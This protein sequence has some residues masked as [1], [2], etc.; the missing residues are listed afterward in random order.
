MQRSPSH[1]DVTRGHGEDGGGDGRVRSG[2]D[3]AASLMGPYK[4]GAGQAGYRG[5][6]DVQV[7]VSS[8]TLEGTGRIKWTRHRIEI[9]HAA[10]ILGYDTTRLYNIRIRELVVARSWDRAS[11]LQLC[12]V[13]QFMVRLTVG[14]L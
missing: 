7:A 6:S 9:S 8:G 5:E 2:S 14:R 13:P 11:A 1:S 4:A 10:V 12:V 3:R